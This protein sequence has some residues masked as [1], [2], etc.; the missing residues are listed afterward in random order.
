[1]FSATVIIT[2]GIIISFYPDVVVSENKESGNPEQYDILCC[3][4]DNCFKKIW[5]SII[6]VNKNWW[7]SLIR[8]FPFTVV[9][10][11]N[12]INEN[13]YNFTVEAF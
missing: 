7:L 3:D 1:M 11:F 5:K 2:L 9:S 8:P 4:H 6:Y 10:S 13:N 12:L